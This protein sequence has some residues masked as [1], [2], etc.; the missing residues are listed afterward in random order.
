MGLELG[1]DYLIDAA[2]GTANRR[3]IKVNI[4]KYIFKTILLEIFNK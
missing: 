2:N 1:D 3:L 4:K